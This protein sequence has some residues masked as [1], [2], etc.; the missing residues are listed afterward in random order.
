MVLG[1]FFRKKAGGKG[2]VFV[3]LRCLGWSKAGHSD[4][5]K[6]KLSSVCTADHP[7]SW[8]GKGGTL[9]SL[10]SLISLIFQSPVP[11]FQPHSHLRSKEHRA[12]GSSCQAGQEST[13]A[14]GKGACFKQSLPIKA[15]F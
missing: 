7:R 8:Q 9:I 6:G 5:N 13:A 11:N 2:A 12:V 1:F 15:E 4:G 14:E 3:P 10:I